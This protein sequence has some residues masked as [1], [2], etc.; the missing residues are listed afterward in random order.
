[1]PYLAS[2]GSVVSTVQNMLRYNVKGVGTDTGI[3]VS[4]VQ[5]MLRYNT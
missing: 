5:N 3:V 2:H 1:M 4:T